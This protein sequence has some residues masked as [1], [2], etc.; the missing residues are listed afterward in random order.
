MKPLCVWLGATSLNFY[1]ISTG[2]NAA[3]VMWASSGFLCGFLGLLAAS[4]RTDETDEPDDRHKCATTFPEL[5]VN[6]FIPLS[7]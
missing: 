7:N 2:I 1:S 4:H 5:L 6:V 3:F